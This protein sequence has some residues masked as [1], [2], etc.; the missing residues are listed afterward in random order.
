MPLLYILPVSFELQFTGFHSWL[1]PL[2]TSTDIFFKPKSLEVEVLHMDLQV[3]IVDPKVSYLQPKVSSHCS[4]SSPLKVLMKALGF[5]DLT[6]Q[7]LQSCVSCFRLL[8]NAF[9]HLLRLHLVSPE[10]NQRPKALSPHV[11][12]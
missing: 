1:K 10:F 12:V 8:A 3:P 9:Y 6:C 5:S 11:C 7:W 2:L 4:V